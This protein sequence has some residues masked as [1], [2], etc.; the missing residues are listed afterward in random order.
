MMLPFR[1]RRALYGDDSP[2]AED[3]DSSSPQPEPE[4]ESKLQPTVK[5]AEYFPSL[6]DVLKIRYL[7]QWKISGG[8]PVELVDVIIDAAEYWPSIECRMKDEVVVGTDRDRVLLKTVPLC[9]DRKRLEN[10]PSPRPLPHRT[11]HPC[12]KIL[13]E[14]SSRDQGWGPPRENMYRCSWTWFDTEVIRGAHAKNMYAGGTEQDLLDNEQGQVRKHYGPNDKN[15][16]PGDDKLQVNGARVSEKQ[17]V[18]IIWHYLDHIKP[19]SPEAH[20]IEHTRG[21]GRSTL[22]GRGVRELE[23]G[24]SIALWARARFMG[25]SN[26]VY[27]AKVRVFWA[28]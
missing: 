27:A 9:Y 23:V 28:V 7:L 5:T 24:D 25:W 19:D 12:R 4:S 11:V 6:W 10:E 20:D 1:L 2:S 13:F 8:L 18:Q 14:L 16:L 21:R 26:H 22:D 3:A 15:L 17:N